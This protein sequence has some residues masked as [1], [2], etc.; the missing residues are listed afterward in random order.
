MGFL[1]NLQPNC[2]LSLYPWIEL[3]IQMFTLTLVKFPYSNLGLTASTLNWLNWHSPVTWFLETTRSGTKM[4]HR[5]TSDGSP[6]DKSID[7][8]PWQ[9]VPGQLINFWVLSWKT[10]IVALHSCPKVS[11]GRKKGQDTPINITTPT[12]LIVSVQWA[13]L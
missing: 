12:V 13:E 10:K 8:Y 6:H 7:V 1:W 4:G 3:I 11:S 2:L 5:P 9:Q